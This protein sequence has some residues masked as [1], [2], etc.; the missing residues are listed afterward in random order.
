[1]QDTPVEDTQPY[2][3]ESVEHMEQGA[4]QDV[5]EYADQTEGGGVGDAEEGYEESPLPPP[6]SDAP[7]QEDEQ[8]EQVTRCTVAEC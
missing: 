4:G 3:D 6:S 5:D 2:E 8:S 1:M 7:E